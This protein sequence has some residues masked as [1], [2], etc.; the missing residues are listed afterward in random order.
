MRRLLSLWISTVLLL[1]T[2]AVSVPA[3]AAGHFSDVD[4]V[5][6]YNPLPFRDG[7]NARYTGTLTDQIKK[8]AIPETQQPIKESFV[9]VPHVAEK[10]H[11]DPLIVEEGQSTFWICADLNTMTFSQEV[12]DLVS[13]SEHCRVW[14]RTDDVLQLTEEEACG[15]ADCF[16]EVIY[17]TVTE[18]FGH[19]RDLAGDGKLNILVYDMNNGS[20]CGF[21]DSYDL[22]SSEEIKILDPNSDA[23]NC[24]PIINVNVRMKDSMDVVRATIAHEY[25]HLVQR[26]AVLESPAN[27][28]RLGREL[29]AGLWLN[30]AFSM[31]AE[32]LCFAGTIQ[33]Q[34]YCRAYSESKMIQNGLSLMNFDAAAND[35]GAY[36]QSFL[37]AEYLKTQFSEEVYAETLQYLRTCTDAEHM[38]DAEALAAAAGEMYATVAECFTFEAPVADRFTSDAEEWLSKLNLCYRLS[39]LVASENGLFYNQ[40]A[41]Q[42]PLYSGSGCKLDGGGAVVCRIES[43]SFTVPFDADPGIMFLGLKDGELTEVY[44]VPE[45]ETGYFVLAVD[46]GEISLALPNAVASGYLRPNASVSDD[47]RNGTVNTSTVQGYI[48]K[49]EG[50]FAEGYTVSY[51]DENGIRYFLG[52]HPTETEQLSVTDLEVRLKI[53]RFRTTGNARISTGTAADRAILYGKNR[54]GF[55]NFTSAYYFS[56]SHLQPRLILVKIIRGDV[57]LNGTVNAADAAE[58]LRSVVDLSTLS[59]TQRLCADVNEDQIA[60]ATDASLLLRSIVGIETLG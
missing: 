20:I 7:A 17:P 6:I 50:S 46:N 60:S 2:F 14:S 39:Q 56:S 43:D 8:E 48:W 44:T 40:T 15:L 29:E 42:P 13:E 25:Q 1:C 33:E 36:G 5:L 49:V 27:A 52:A 28:E 9:A 58:L 31:E 54:H 30:E 32:E 4:T 51:V 21:F 55:G 23:Y 10:T 57:D 53:S 3:E 11:R 41:A 16:R 34:G 37:F 47:L 59:Q 35:V 12:F 22:Y 38:T 26:T 24:L 45:Q 19:F 18:R